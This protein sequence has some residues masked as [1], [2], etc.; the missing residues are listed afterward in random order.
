MQA[1]MCSCQTLCTCTSNSPAVLAALSSR[2]TDPFFTHGHSP[3]GS[4]GSGMGP[5]HCMPVSSS[6]K[7][8]L[9]IPHMK[10]RGPPTK[11]SS[12]HSLISLSASRHQYHPGT[13]GGSSVHSSARGRAFHAA[14]ASATVFLDGPAMR[15]FLRFPQ[16]I[17][18]SEPSC[19]PP[20]SGYAPHAG[21]GRVFNFSDILFSPFP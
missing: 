4:C 5:A 7:V 11:F 14:T 20:R 17:H 19:E 1:T 15:H 12:W 2:P 10:R 18:N 9:E 6:G 3:F 21:H 16:A 8:C 13:F